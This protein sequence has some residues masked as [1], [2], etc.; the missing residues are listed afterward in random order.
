MDP[1]TH[2]LTGA[3]AA[4]FAADEPERKKAMGVGF[5]AALLADLDIFIQMP[6]NPL[7]AIEVHR[8]F[9]HSLMFIPIGALIAAGVVMLLFKRHFVFRQ[10]YLYSLAG[11]A[12]SGLMDALTS[13]G[14]V[15]FWPFS[16]TRI[17]W[18]LISVVDPLLT[19]GL[20]VAVIVSF[21][22][23]EL[24]WALFGAG[25][26]LLFMLTGS[27]QQHRATQAALQIAEQRGHVVQ[28]IVVKP[29]IG[30]QL[31]W[32]STYIHG[33]TVQ[34]DGIRAGLGGI[35]M[36][37]GESA[38][39]VV[40]EHD[41]NHLQGT[42]LY[43]D[44]QRMHALSDGFLVRHRTEPEV[45]GDARYSMLPTSMIPLWGVRL[46]T[47][48]PGQHLD[49]EYFRDAGPEI[50]TQFTDMLLGRETDPTADPQ[51]EP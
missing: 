27:I 29:T 17:A 34:T 16:D 49:F 14:T 28:S 30:N 18:N 23:T 35:R 32:R 7:F 22:R 24:R 47:A 3:V 50:R 2:G 36:Y 44:V 13:Y 40:P 46:D 43:H 8:Q 42:T 31:L 41:L 37:E 10:V 9:T 45:I 21:Y 33:T 1:L 20:L 4:R 25:W 38:P 6:G 5:F 15:L 51:T 12:T 26:I 11:Y 19:A 48:R 39:L